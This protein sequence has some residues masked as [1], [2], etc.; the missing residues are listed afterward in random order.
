MPRNSPYSSQNEAPITPGFE[1][2]RPPKPVQVET[3]EVET[4]ETPTDNLVVTSSGAKT[5]F[6]RNSADLAKLLAQL[7]PPKPAGQTEDATIETYSDSY[8]DL[9]DKMSA[10]SDAATKALISSI[11][12]KSSRREAETRDMYDSYSRALHGLGIQQNRAQSTPELLAGQITKINMDKMKK[13]EE[14]DAE[15]TK[16]IMDA[17]Q[18]QLDKDFKTLREKMDYIKEIRKQK[19]EELKALYDRMNYEEKISEI[20]AER[21]YSGLQNL[22]VA[23][24]EIYLQKVADQL[25]VPYASLA[26]AVYNVHTARAKKKKTGASI[27]KFNATQKNKLV[28]AGLNT[29][30]IVNIE[31]DI[32]NYG[33]DVAL[34]GIGDSKQQA[35]VR[36]L[37][38]DE[39]D[40][41]GFS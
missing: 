38:V 32:N 16:A 28:G 31:S 3:P 27:I 25:N 36:A 18:A 8:T 11:K 29:R 2:L 13:L 22:G 14:Y 17:Q 7:N 10:K 19:G 24:K 30:D 41:D 21:I 15:E 40:T 1:S 23:E 26:N 20:Q 35:T 39:E 4:P 33:L 6:T 12:A 37:F 5:E 34:E 9:L